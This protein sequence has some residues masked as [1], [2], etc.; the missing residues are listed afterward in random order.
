MIMM[1]PM[2]DSWMTMTHGT[3]IDKRREGT[4]VNSKKYKVIFQVI[5]EVEAINEDDAA[6]RAGEIWNKGDFERHSMIEEVL[7]RR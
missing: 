3:T 5:M 6:R 1:M 2:T 4:M 7:R